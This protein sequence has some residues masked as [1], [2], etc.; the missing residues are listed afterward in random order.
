MNSRDKI[1]KAIAHAGYPDI[2]KPKFSLKLIDYENIV[3]VFVDVSKRVGSDTIIVNSHDQAMDYFQKIKNTVNAIHEDENQA[4]DRN[5]LLL[6]ES[7]LAVSENGAIW[8]DESEMAHRADPFACKH[9]CVVVNARDI[10]S[11]M[12][13]AYCQLN[14]LYPSVTFPGFGVFIAGP[15]KTADIEQTLVIG[16]QGTQKHTIILITS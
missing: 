1:I 16:A 8:L 13:D 9:L 12:H 14:C 2:A 4:S 7:R 11:N 15:S 5:D 3:N 10:V 6:I